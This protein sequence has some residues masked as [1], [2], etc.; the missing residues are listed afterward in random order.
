MV[1]E[2]DEAIKGRPDTTAQGVAGVVQKGRNRL[3]LKFALALLV[4]FR[5]ARALCHRLHSPVGIPGV[6]SV[7]CLFPGAFPPRGKRRP[8]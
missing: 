4:P 2:R 5:R 6:L 1:K 7:P 3:V 8:N